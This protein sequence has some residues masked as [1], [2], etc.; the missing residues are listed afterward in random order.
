MFFN[1]FDE[2]YQKLLMAQY[3]ISEMINHK[4]TRWEVREDFL[5]SIILEQFPSLQTLSW[6][7]TD[8]KVQSPQTDII[9]TD[10]SCRTRKLWSKNL[11]NIDDCKMILEVKSNATW[12]DFKKFN[13]D[14]WK[15]KALWNEKLLCWIFCY[16]TDL[17][18]NTL[19]NRF[20][21]KYN[22][23]YMMYENYDKSL[24]K[25]P[26]IDFVISIDNFKLDPDIDEDKEVFIIFDKEKEI[27]PTTKEKWGYSFIIDKPSLKN[28]FNLL[29]WINR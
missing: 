8:D 23:Q 6:I 4:L 21:Y 2:Y 1:K 17:K 24:I 15:I 20:W 7:I 14:A 10:F 22:N 26:N 19:L 5:K 11:V 18:L 16:R 9:I 13:I 27:N 28:L 3:D 12:D 29:S 25:Y